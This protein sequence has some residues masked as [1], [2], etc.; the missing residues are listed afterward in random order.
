M[1]QNNNLPILSISLFLLLLAI[2]FFGFSFIDKN[3]NTYQNNP[4][5]YGSP[6]N[7]D[8]EMKGFKEGYAQA[9]FDTNKQNK[10][11]SVP[12]FQYINNPFS[13]EPAVVNKTNLVNN[14]TIP[15]SSVATIKNSD[16][17]SD[18]IDIS[19][20]VSPTTTKPKENKKTI[21]SNIK[22]PSF[23]DKKELFLKDKKDYFN[24]SKK[25]NTP[26]IKVLVDK[27]VAI[28]STHTNNK[29]TDIKSFGS[30]IL[31]QI[32]KELNE[33]KFRHRNSNIKY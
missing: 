23:E 30:D 13:P 5:N 24:S 28:L 25:Q 22:K 10:I 11:N 8:L 2:A 15:S 31:K 20:S 1:N 18:E 9:L 21:I 32:E 27:K 14:H 26:V 29:N 17:S 16:F 3:N 4:T 7:I 19:P 33:A 6:S 12:V